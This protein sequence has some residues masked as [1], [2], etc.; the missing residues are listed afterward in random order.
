MLASLLPG[1]RDVRSAL[2]AGYMWFCAGW[3]LIGHYHPP[4]AGLLARPAVELLELFGTGGR[5]AVISVL[6]L[7]IGEVT[8][9]LVQAFFYRVCLGYLRRL[10]ADDL[11]HRPRGLLSVFRPV[12]GRAV[13]RVRSRARKEYRKHQEATV[14][15]ASPRGEDRFEVDRRAIEAL[16]EVLHMSPRLIVAKPELHAE[17]GRIKAESEFRDAILL[18][19]PILTVAVCANLSAP[20]WLEAAIVVA[21]C[22]ADL[23]LFFEARRLF[24]EAHSM[25]AH[26][27][28]DGTISSAAMSG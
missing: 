13:A 19:L 21:I 14:S 3:L 6:C 15:D 5:L 12:S 10:T 18:P 8:S 28:A 9:R 17:F 1:F 25:I 7:L 23:Y 24:R 22:V 11:D 27:L 16:G 4:P 26:S 20:P 2:V